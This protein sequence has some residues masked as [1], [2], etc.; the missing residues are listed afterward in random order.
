[1]VRFYATKVGV[2]LA[3]TREMHYIAKKLMDHD[4]Q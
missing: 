4:C 3:Y 2:L 1:M